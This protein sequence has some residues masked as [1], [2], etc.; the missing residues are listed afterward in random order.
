MKILYILP[1]PFFAACD[2]AT[3]ARN[4]LSALGEAGHDVDL[5]CHPWGDDLRLER[6]R[7]LRAWRVPG[8]RQTDGVSFGRIALHAILFLRAAWLCWRNRY[9]VVHAVEEA[10]FFAPWLKRVFGCRFV[11][12]MDSV[13]SANLR[14]T[15][16]FPWRLLAGPA[17]RRERNAM[18]QAEFVLT[19]CSSLTEEV[20]ARAPSCRVVQIEDA[21]MQAD[22]QEDA[23]GAA[24][25]RRSL[26]LEEGPSVLVCIGNL[27]RQDGVDLLLRAVS[28]VRRSRPNVRCCIVG[29]SAAQVARLVYLA[30]SLDVEPACIFTGW[31]S[32]DD[33]PA[34]VTL[35][36]VLVAPQ[37]SGRHTAMR[38]YTYMQSGRPIV[39]TRIGAHTQV[40]DDECAVLV[41]PD[42]DSLAAGILQ[43]L[44]EPLLAAALG[45]ESRGRVAARYSLASFRHKV[46]SAYQL[47]TA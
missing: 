44:R 43:I 34:F 12:D 41:V 27:G 23:E 35:A 28:I 9:D 4:L 16:G 19:F 10:A 24:R 20:R 42:A 21:P 26:G 45:R 11:Y 15:A 18:K 32:P 40:L 47:L 37:V 22:F 36:T 5:L 39:A 3:N 1:R 2:A 29:G 31:R 8:L 14:L 46:R 6:V 17:E 38:V 13:V 7:I 30:R 25:V 33:I